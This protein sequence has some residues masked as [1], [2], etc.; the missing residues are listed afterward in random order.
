[1]K[2]KFL[3][4]KAW[5]SILIYLIIS[6]LFFIIIAHNVLMGKINFQFYADTKTYEKVARL[7]NM[8]SLVDV[9]WNLFGPVKI[10]SILG[11]QNYWGLFIFNV[12]ILILALYYISRDKSVYLRKLFFLIIISPIT[13]FSLFSVNKEIIS[14]LCISLIIYNHTKNKF[15]ITL[16]ILFM[17]YLVRWQFTMFY[18]IY[19]L[20]YSRYNFLKNRKAISFT[21]LLVVIS[22]LLFFVQYTMFSD[23]FDVYYSRGLKDHTTGLGSFE[24]IMKIQTKLG[25]IFAFIPKT[26]H[27]MTGMIVRYR[28]VLDFSDAYNNFV[29]FFQAPLNLYL[30]FLNYKR[31][32]FSFK[33]EYF[34]MALLYCAVF[35]ITPVYA[36]RYFYPV[37]ILLA[38]S[39]AASFD[40]NCAYRLKKVHKSFQ[41]HS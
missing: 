6:V 31:R 18:L 24:I 34:F 38:Y 21:L 37:S 9:G 26:L 20:F 22:I 14:L 5:G 10:L 19:L 4:N 2:K 33:N 7:G 40:V 41:N 29:L 32:L 11:Y 15:L 30:L 3:V 16:L 13:F 39:Y 27:L 23:L 8:E 28:Y 35:A 17:S 25:Y 12:F 36:I 1:M